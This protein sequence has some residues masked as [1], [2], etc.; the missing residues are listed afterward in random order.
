M[1]AYDAS[2]VEIAD[3][4]VAPAHGMYIEVTSIDG[5]AKAKYTYVVDSISDI[6]FDVEGNE[7]IYGTI[8]AKIHIVNS[9]EEKTEVGKLFIAKYEGNKLV[10]I[11]FANVDARCKVGGYVDNVFSAPI[12]VIDSTKESVKAFYFGANGVKPL[13]DDKELSVSSTNF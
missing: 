2:G 13:K 10:G 8:S 7:T 5:L 1:K 3:T 12:D 4:S 6:F 11:N 9:D